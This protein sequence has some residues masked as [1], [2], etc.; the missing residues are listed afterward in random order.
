MGVLKPVGAFF[1]VT[2]FGILLSAI[3]Y[4]MNTRGILIDELVTGSITIT[5]VMALVILC[6]MLLGGIIAV[7]TR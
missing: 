1:G 6:F 7:L 3:F 2:C 4:E 5:D